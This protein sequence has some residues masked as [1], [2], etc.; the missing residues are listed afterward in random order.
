DAVQRY[1]KPP[2]ETVTASL[3]HSTVM[4]KSLLPRSLLKGDGDIG[5][6]PGSAPKFSSVLVEESPGSPAAP[7]P[8]RCPP[9]LPWFGA[10]PPLIGLGLPVSPGS[11]P[12]VGGEP[13]AFIPDSWPAGRAELGAANPEPCSYGR[14]EP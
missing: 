10:E 1:V 2:G 6:L 14:E 13:W 8:E 5:F 12:G 7:V 4:M 9:A 3:R 11:C